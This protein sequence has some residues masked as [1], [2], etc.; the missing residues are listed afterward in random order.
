M[1]LLA[2]LDEAG[3]IV[4]VVKVN[5]SVG[6]THT[7]FDM[8]TTTLNLQKIVHHFITN[9]NFVPARKQNGAPAPAR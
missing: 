5:G 6:I 9:G 3:R 2:Q 8:A 1:G 4:I 7:D